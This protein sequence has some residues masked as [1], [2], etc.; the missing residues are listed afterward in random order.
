MRTVRSAAIGIVS[1]AFTGFCHRLYRH[2][3]YRQQD[4]VARYE[5]PA[6]QV[7]RLVCLM[8]AVLG[9]SL[10]HGSERGWGEISRPTHY[11]Y[12]R[13][14]RGANER[15]GP[16]SS[17]PAISMLSPHLTVATF[18]QTALGLLSGPART[19]SESRENERPMFSCADDARPKRN[20]KSTTV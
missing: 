16:P 6:V 15:P 10:T 8:G 13:P 5:R 17:R 12:P 3:L 19:S 14:Q 18:N 1:P 7:E 20:R 9:E 2:R 11:L 4:D